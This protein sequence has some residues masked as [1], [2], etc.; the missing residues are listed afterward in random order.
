MYVCV[1]IF[2]DREWERE[3]IVWRNVCDSWLELMDMYFWKIF[4]VLNLF[5]IKV[6]GLRVYNYNN[7]SKNI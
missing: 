6:G 4:V 5:K 3:K 7:D 1:F 2:I